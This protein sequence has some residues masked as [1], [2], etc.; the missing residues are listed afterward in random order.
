MKNLILASLLLLSACSATGPTYSTLDGTVTKASTGTSKIV[1]YREANFINGGARY[2]VELN[3][4]EVCKLHQ[5][6]FLIHDVHPGIV[7]VAASNFGSLGTSR[8]TVEVKPGQTVYV[9][10]AVNGSRATVGVLGGLIASAAEEGIENNSGPVFLGEV[11][12]Q[13]ASQEMAAMNMDCQ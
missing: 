12:K 10:M 2:W 1:I 9:K 4:V 6:S 7:N 8:M 5:A 11:S 3:G 13:V